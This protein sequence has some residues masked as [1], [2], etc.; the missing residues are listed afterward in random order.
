MFIVTK[1]GVIATDPIAYGRPTGGQTHVDEIKKVTNQPIKYL[2]YSHH[3]YDHIA[4]GKAFKDAGAR[5]FAHRKVKEHLAPLGDPN[6]VLPGESFDGKKTITLGGT[7]LELSYIGPSHSDS[8]IVMRLPKEKITFVVDTI[9]IGYFPGRGMI[10]FYPLETE[11]FIKKV[12]VSQHLLSWPSFLISAEASWY[13]ASTSCASFL[14]SSR[15]PGC[16][17]WPGI[18]RSQSIGREG[19]QDAEIPTCPVM[20]RAPA[21]SHGAIAASGAAAPEPIGGRCSPP[22]TR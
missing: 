6:T 11:V 15:P 17:G 12:V 7:T 19:I 2:I 18:S 20:K 8:N 1:A 5:I 4:D 9:P 10:N 14:L 16:P 22:P 21:W 3:H 13:S